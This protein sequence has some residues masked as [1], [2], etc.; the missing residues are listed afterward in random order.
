MS[1][2]TPLD[3]DALTPEQRA[4]V[5]AVEHGPR[6]ARH[7][8]IGMAGPFGVWLHAPTLGDAA[9][10]FGAVVRFGTTLPEHVKEVAIC[11]VGAHFKAR[12]EFAAHA[13]LAIAAGVDPAAIEAIRCGRQPALSDPAQAL[14]HEITRTLLDAHRLSDT[15]YRDARAVFS[16]AE[17]V[18]LVTVI[19]YYCQISLTLNAFEVP[20]TPGMADP[21]TD[22]S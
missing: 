12:F 9:Q 4:L 11:T 13:P 19:G 1:R 16:E 2:L 8:S 14:A 22:A 18:E 10:R 3:R 5:E 6:A 7:G 21:F 20:L 17:L 15:Q